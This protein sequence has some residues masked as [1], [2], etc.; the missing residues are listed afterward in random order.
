MAGRKR[1]P[2]L[3]TARHVKRVRRLPSRE[4]ALTAHGESIMGELLAAGLLPSA[5]IFAVAGGVV[6]LVI[7]GVLL[8]KAARMTMRENRCKQL[9]THVGRVEAQWREEAAM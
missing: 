7:V 5:P 3:A 2:R 4:C 1:P 6:V 9:R 8:Q